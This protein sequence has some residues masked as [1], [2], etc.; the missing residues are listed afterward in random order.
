MWTSPQSVLHNTHKNWAGYRI[1]IWEVS[2][3]SILYLAEV[4]HFVQHFVHFRNH[5]LP[6]YKY[7]HI[8]TISQSNMKHSSVLKQ[9]GKKNHEAISKSYP[10]VS[11]AASR[12]QYNLQSL[13]I[14]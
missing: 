5:I 7:W 2:Y 3:G 6:I 13:K 14:L 11:D 10:G 12:R 8:G 4:F 9:K 1:I